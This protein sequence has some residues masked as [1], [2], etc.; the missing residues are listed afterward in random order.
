[1]TVIDVATR[2]VVKTLQTGTQPLAVAYSPLSRSVYVADGKDGNV[3]VIDGDQA[4]DRQPHRAQ[5]RTRPAAHE[6]R[7][8]VSRWCSI[9]GRTW[10]T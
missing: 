7:T 3:T 6:P 10:C 8:A 2:K 9:R 1:M 4:R 5:G